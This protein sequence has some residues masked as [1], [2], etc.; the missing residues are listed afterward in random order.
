MILG[1]LAAVWLLGILLARFLY[2]VPARFSIDNVLLVSLGAGLGIGVASSLYFLCLAAAGPGLR[3]LGLVE[4]GALVGALALAAIFRR[5]IASLDWTAGPAAPN[6]LAWLFLAGT[7]LAVSVFI[8]QTVFKPHGDV[9]AWALWNLRARF[10][11]RSGT[12]WSHTF[13]NQIAWSHPGYPLLV[14]GAVAMLWTLAGGEAQLA[15]MGV[16]FLFTLATA[17]LLTSGL[18]ILRGKLPA[19][20]AGIVLLGSVAFVQNGAMQYAD[21]PFGFYVLATVVLVCLQQRFAED[22]RFSIAAGLMAGF[23]AWTKNEGLLFA[24]AIAV[25]L[26]ISV[27]RFGGARLGRQ[28]GGFLAG[29]A[30]P[31]ATVLLFKL[32]FAPADNFFARSMRELLANFA[33]PGRWIATF[34]ALVKAALQLGSFLVPVILVL[35]LYWYLVRIGIDP[36]DRAGVAI[37][38]IALAA[39][40]AGEIGA[41][42]LLPGEVALEVVSSMDRVLLQ[43]F[44]AALFVFFLAARVP[45]LTV[46]KAKPARQAAKPRRTAETR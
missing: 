37:S 16:A 43:M 1:C 21:V 26:P 2:P 35:A 28:S 42:I 22:A 29:L 18:G 4:G 24:A 38:G 8:V 34:T 23:A 14:P 32:R 44:P 30:L 33:D 6:Y 11:F 46:D 10:L 3:L 41:G 13:S 12:S 25:A 9:N 31:L 36:R 39:L 19:W 27:R 20:L 45:Q 40:L 15:P 5:R 17:A 7:G